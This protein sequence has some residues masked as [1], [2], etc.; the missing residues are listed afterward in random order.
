[1]EPDL[2]KPV[3]TDEQ[4]LK[5]FDKQWLTR[6]VTGA[7]SE[8]IKL[9]ESEIHI[10]FNIRRPPELAIYFRSQG[11]ILIGYFAY[12]L[13]IDPFTIQLRIMRQGCSF[14]ETTDSKSY[15]M[16]KTAAIEKLM[17]YPDFKEWLLWNRP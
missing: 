5:F 3:F 8:R 4:I 7:A 9:G 1:M 17:T 11:G 16:T 15:L 6:C 13:A 2:N 12:S 10:S 14:L